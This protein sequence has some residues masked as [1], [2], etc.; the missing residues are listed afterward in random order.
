MVIPVKLTLATLK[1][2]LDC[3]G[4]A[5]TT[6]LRQMKKTNKCR[7]ILNAHD[8][9]DHQAKNQMLIINQNKTRCETISE[10]HE[11]TS[12]LYICQCVCRA[13]LT[14]PMSVCPPVCFGKH[15]HTYTSLCFLMRHVIYF[16]R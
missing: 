11:L 1:D 12:T 2:H 7:Y 6:V 13:A 3:S 4:E 16:A 10:V 5:I 15:K 9:I 14:P 8:L